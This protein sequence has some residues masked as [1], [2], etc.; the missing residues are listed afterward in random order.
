MP[1]ASNGMPRLGVIGAGGYATSTLLPA[2]HKA[3][4][5]VQMIASNSGVSGLH[6]QR[7]FGI[8][9]AT[10]DALALINDPALDAVII[11]T[12]HSSHAAL[13]CAA[14]KAGKSVFVEKP[15]AL[16]RAEL[17]EIEAVWRD[18]RARAR[19]PFLTVGFNRRFAPHVQAIEKALALR[20]EPAAFIMTVNAGALPADHWTQSVDE[21]G[22]II[23][24]ACHFVDLLRYLAGSPITQADATGR[25]DTATLQLGFANCSMGTVH[26]L[27]NG[28]RSF[29]KERLEIFCGGSILVLDNFRKLTV[30]NWRGMK[31]MRLWRQNK[32]QAACVE[33]Y[34]TACKSGGPSPI[35]FKDLLEVAGVTIDLAAQL[36]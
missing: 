35:P 19:P 28:A 27:A 10:T 12:R 5:R 4:A 20:S 24:E 6:A 31:P 33:A 11:A 13:T 8:A 34:L 21:G 1:V 15:L 3:G 7:K 25:G 23:G 9:Q 22:R 36:R 18:A 30:H 29:P 26:Y 17:S 14:L 16:N 32:G 2:L